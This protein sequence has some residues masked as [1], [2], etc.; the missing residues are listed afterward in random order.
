MT[1]EFIKELPRWGKGD[2]CLVKKG[3]EYFVLSSVFAAFT[4]FETL[5]FRSTN[6]G[7]VAR[8]YGMIEV[9][10]G[11]GASRESVILQIELDDELG[12]I[13]G[14]ISPLQIEKGS[15]E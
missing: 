8:P 7:E 3:D 2:A 10:G 6:E 11:P 9:A 4:G 5:A 14:S 12:V 15:D 13:E 1:V